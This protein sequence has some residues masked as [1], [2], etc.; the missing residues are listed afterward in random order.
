MRGMIIKHFCTGILGVLHVCV[1][2]YV[3][4]DIPGKKRELCKATKLAS[5][6]V[7]AVEPPFL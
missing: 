3:H 7:G 4:E 1:Y 6:K 2:I 5:I